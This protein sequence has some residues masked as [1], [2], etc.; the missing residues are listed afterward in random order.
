MMCQA[1]YVCVAAPTN[2]DPKG[3]GSSKEKQILAMGAA[4]PGAETF[5]VFALG[6]AKAGQ[7]CML[8]LQ[9]RKTDRI[10]VGKG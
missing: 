7:A 8:N 3:L 10:R 6:A 2:Q 5:G 1:I 4:T 9:G